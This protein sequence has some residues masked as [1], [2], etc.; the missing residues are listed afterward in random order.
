MNAYSFDKNGYYVGEVI[1]QR[2]QVN[3]GKFL[4]PG[5]ATFKSPPSPGQDQEAKWD[6]SKWAL[7]VSR[8][9]KAADDAAA[10]PPLPPDPQI[11]A[12]ENQMKSQRVGAICIATLYSLIDAKNLSNAD[13]LTF[14][15]NA[16]FILLERLLWAGV[17]DKAKLVLAKI[18]SSLFTDAEKT[19]IVNLVKK[20]LGS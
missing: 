18:D 4:L 1:C 2:D 10:N 3:K 5:H 14:L 15:G 9:K 16:D 13:W 6:G 19:Q 20:F 17:I 8:E 11:V 7:V 12:I